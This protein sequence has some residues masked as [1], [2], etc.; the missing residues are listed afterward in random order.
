VLVAHSFW[1]PGRGFC[2]WAEDSRL[3]GRSRR[4][5]DDELG[6]R[7]HSFAVAAA[8][9]ATALGLTAEAAARAEPVRLRLLLPT[10]G[11]RPLPSTPAKAGGRAAPPNLLPL[12]PPVRRNVRRAP[13]LHPWMV[14]TLQL[15][16]G[17]ALELLLSRRA[18]GGAPERVA[19]ESP[20]ATGAGW[21]WCA[22]LADEA[23]EMAAGGR[24]VPAVLRASDGRAEARWLP[25][26][27]AADGERLRA[28]VESI[29]SVCRAETETARDRPAGS[30]EEI[31]TGALG[32]LVDAAVRASLAGRRTVPVRRGRVSKKTAAAE[33]FLAAL[34][35]DEATLPPAAADAANVEELQTVLRDWRR[36]G[37][38]TAGPLR[39]CFRL[40]PPPATEPDPVTHP[41]PATEADPAGEAPPSDPGDWDGDDD[42]F[43]EEPWRVEILLQSTADPSLLVPAGDV[44]DD[45]P[46]FEAFRPLVADPGGH[47]RTDLGRAVRLWPG[48]DTALNS[49]APSEV[50]LD[51]AGAQRFL[52]DAA[53]LLE[54]A[55]FGILVPP[56]WQNTPRLG[57]RLRA[58][59]RPVGLSGPS[60][61]GFGLAGLCDYDYEVAVGDATLSV[62]ELQR[63]AEAKAPLVRLKGRWVELR[64]GDIERAL[65]ILERPDGGRAPARRNM[66]AAEV[67][68]VGLGLDPPPS[69]DLP[70]VGVVAEGWLGALLGSGGEAGAGEHV[71][72]RIEALPTPAGFN[73]VLRPY[74]ERGLAW[75]SFLQRYGLGACLAD[76]MGL[77]KT[78]QLLALMVSEREEADRRDDPESA[79]PGATLL[80]CPMSLVG[81]WQRETERFAPGLAVH[82]H[83]G[84]GRKVGPS[85]VAAAE[86]TDMVITTYSLLARDQKYLAQIPWG[87]VALDEAQNVK[88]PLSLAGRA[89]R[90]LPAAGRVALTG[91]PVENRLLELWS[92]MDFLNPGLLGSEATFRHRFAVPVERYGDEAAAATLKQLTGPFVLRRLKTDRSIIADLPDKIEMHVL[93]NLT[94]EQASLYRAVVDDMLDRIEKSKTGIERMGIIS[95]SMMKLKQVCNH[96]A[97]FLGDGSRLDGDR[98]GK[99]ARLEEV[100]EEVTAAGERALVFTQFAEMGTLLQTHLSEMLGVELPFLYGAV[101][102]KRREEMVDS[103]QSEGGP[104]VLILTLKAGGVGLNLTAANHVVHYD[105]WWNPAVEDQAT[106]R[107]FRIG[108]ERNVQ[109][110]KFVC[111][112]TLEERIDTM[113]E[114]KRDLAER[115]VGSGEARLTDLSLA[116]LRD[117]VALSEDA[118]A[119]G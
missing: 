66:T 58:R 5:E 103:F 46:A 48:L 111:V 93:C 75:L 9:L 27:T 14:P 64:A 119:E 8:G 50:E 80:V 94:R 54:Q 96:P 30:P 18:A 104:P 89:A 57:L 62:Q 74:Q 44:W 22:A 36:S 114:A 1:S 4:G 85:L 70:V 29:P 108:Q 19:T 73:G 91:T 90:S 2:F 23:L 100:L 92:L 10:E 39:T 81:N 118:V 37:L 24:A 35:A 25:A 11:S 106:D 115:I 45:G 17:V 88:N 56:W 107:A 95:G 51:A 7:R 55:G 72:D 32:D 34:T 49:D 101:T 112:G 42:E 109:V 26:P 116:E 33:A 83:H 84:V 3:V 65:A 20:I 13:G 105:R 61:G 82:V 67:L 98:S 63:L 40:V 76:D 77:G 43:D 52:S 47:L 38:S 97:H 110:R 117:L 60:T 59:P 53:P 16:A 69:L 86:K 78:A 28:L 87:R 102:K 68:R 6:P 21:A 71:D 79:R 41:A 12:V 113:I 31:V 99:L 15:P